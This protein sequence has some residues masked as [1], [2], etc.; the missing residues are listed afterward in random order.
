M[1]DSPMDYSVHRILQAKILE[2]VTFPFSRDLSNPGIEPRS[3][4]LQADSLTAELLGK[5][6]APINYPLSIY[7]PL[8]NYSII[9][10]MTTGWGGHP[11]YEG[12]KS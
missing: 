4:A 3:P 5:P 7:Y 10:M 12:R 11:K 6:K 9:N 8:S 1:S 2:W